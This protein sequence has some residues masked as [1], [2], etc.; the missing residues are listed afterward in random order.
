MRHL[1]VIQRYSPHGLGQAKQPNNSF[2]S[3]FSH[4]L[5]FLVLILP[6][7]ARG[8]TSIFNRS[9]SRTTTTRGPEATISRGTT[10][11]TMNGGANIGRQNGMNFRQDQGR[12]FNSPNVG[13]ERS[14]NSSS[15]VGRS[16]APSQNFGRSFGSGRRSFTASQGSPGGFHGGGF[17]GGGHSS[18]GFSGGSHSSAGFNGGRS[19]SG[20]SG[21]ARSGSF[22]GG[23]RSMGSFSG[24]GGRGGG[25]GGDH[26]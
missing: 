12:V 5:S 2:S 8:A 13:R 6:E 14:F 15:A 26:R 16:S 19:S 4:L 21:G 23:S 17:S 24:G 25:H 10:G 7:S 18:G 11:R 1:K 20:F 9:V 22:S 3:H